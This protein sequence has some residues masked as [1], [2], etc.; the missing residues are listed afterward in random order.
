MISSS[1]ARNKGFLSFSE[2]GTMDYKGVF[3]LAGSCAISSI[4]PKTDYN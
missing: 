4:L 1:I 2:V 3:L